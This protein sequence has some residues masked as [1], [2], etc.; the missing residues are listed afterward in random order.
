M[1][2]RSAFSTLWIYIVQ[3][4][5]N[6]LYT[7]SAQDVEKRISLHNDGKGAKYTR[8]R[9]PVKLI[10][11][12][13]CIDRSSALKREAEIKKLTRSEKQRL[14]AG[15]AKIGRNTKGSA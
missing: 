12:E 6:T 5:N 14:I 2:E 11:S 13:E 1:A 7:G 4:S 8:S 15:S 10:Y 9:L 3:C